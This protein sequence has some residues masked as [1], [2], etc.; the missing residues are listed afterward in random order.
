MK[1]GIF[2]GHYLPQA[3]GAH[4]FV[5]DLLLAF[6]EKAR[7]SSHE[8][9]VFCDRVG[10]QAICGKASSST[11]TIVEL[12][13]PSRFGKIIAGLK[14]LSPV[15]RLAWRRPGKFQ[16]LAERHGVQLMWFAGVGVYDS[17][18]VPYVATIWDLQHRLQPFFPEVSSKGLWDQRELISSYFLR[19]AAFCITGTEAGKNEVERFYQLDSERI[20]VIPFP[21]PQFALQDCASS[22]NLRERFGIPGRFV[23]YPAQFWPHKN[24]INLVLALKKLHERGEGDLSL[25]LPGSD[26]GNLEFVKGV[27]R[28]VGLSDRVFFPGFVSLEEL[29]ALYREA[30]ALA[31]MTYFGPDNIP[32]LEAFGLKCP[33]VASNV[34]G[35][36]EQ[37]GDAALLANPSDP[38][39][40]SNALFA[41]LNDVSLRER[42]V[43]AGVARA[44]RWTAAQYVNEMFSIVDGFSAI[45]R[46]W[47]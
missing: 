41:V 44:R 22:I 9:V 20:R 35:A 32:P 4:T 30:S 17:P 47:R 42:L 31:F 12:Q 38:E 6:A 46:N 19:R 28:E 15:A 10:A 24:H 27:C 33:V 2:F 39:D 7:E 3:G 5:G 16:R 21:T 45:R 11:L 13:P 37:F 26:K 18:D 25:V 34:D 40:I 8:F 43:A 23:L 29:I 14:Y 36:A 1:V